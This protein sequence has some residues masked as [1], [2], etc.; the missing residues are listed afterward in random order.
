MS[1][2]PLHTELCNLLDIDY[3]VILAGMGG[4]AGPSLAAAVSNAGGLGVIGCTGFPLDKL[5]EVIRKTKILTP[6]PFG[7]D[8]LEPFPVDQLPGDIPSDRWR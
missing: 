4:Y 8:I 1:R 6:R 2:T 5:S 3:P 7:V